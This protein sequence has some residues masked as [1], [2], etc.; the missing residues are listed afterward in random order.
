MELLTKLSACFFW[1]GFSALLMMCKK[2]DGDSLIRTN[3]PPVADAGADIT[4]N[5]VSCSSPNWVQLDASSSSDADRDKLLYKWTK[6]SGP[7]CSLFNA[8]SLVVYVSDLQPGQ[9]TF[10][11][12]V[13]D[14]DGLSS[15][16]TMAIN[17]TGTPSPTEVDL[18]VQVNGNYSFRISDEFGSDDVYMFLCQ[19]LHSCPVRDVKART[20]LLTTFDV[21]TWGKFMFRIVEIADTSAA[22]NYHQTF[23]TI[24]AAN[25]QIPSGRIS[26]L[27]SVNFKQLIQGG[28]GSFNGTLEMNSGSAG[29]CDPNVFAGLSPLTISGT[30]DTTN[31]IVSLTLKGKT[32]F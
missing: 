25:I 10:E 22:N 27:A 31:H 11:L 23:L 12:D 30:L 17:V 13:T 15:K 3:H 20:N 6:I 4:L 19:A 9:Y 29:G 32:Y 1:I 2:D 21:P 18:D 14:P 28:G 8:D 5:R 16:D 7:S 26:G 24:T